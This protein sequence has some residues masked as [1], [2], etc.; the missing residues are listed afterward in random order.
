MVKILPAESNRWKDRDPTGV[1]PCFISG[2]KCSIRRAYVPRHIRGPIDQ[3]D[4]VR[5]E[6]HL[7]GFVVTKTVPA[8]RHSVV[9]V[10]NGR[11]H[12]NSTWQ[13]YRL[14]GVQVTCWR[15]KLEAVR[16]PS[17]ELGFCCAR[18]CVD[19]VTT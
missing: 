18:L 7:A 5:S 15:G 11:G 12:I 2:S 14:G 8:E 13:A 3:Y 6:Q 19:C 17:I 4:L 9:C 1:D 10:A 16:N